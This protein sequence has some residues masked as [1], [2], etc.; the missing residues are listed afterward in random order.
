MSRPAGQDQFELDRLK[1][2]LLAPETDRLAAVEDRVKALDAR[3]GAP[4]RLEKATAEIL[5]EAFRNAEIARHR[6]LANAVAPVIVAAMRSEIRNSKDMMVEALYPITGRLV[7]AAVA[8]AFRD[9]VADLNV[10]LE[11]TLSTQHWRLRLRALMTGRSMS[12]VALAEAQSPQLRR[13]LLLERGS[14]RLIAAWRADGEADETSELVSGL[15]AAITE[16][17]ANVYQAH[18]GEL[19]TLDLGQTRVFLRATPAYLIAADCAGPLRAEDER[20]FD[21]GVLHLVGRLDSGETTPEEGV[22]AVAEGLFEQV[23]PQ[24]K[25]GSRWRLW[26]VALALVALAAWAASGPVLRQMKD[27]AIAA[28][29]AQAVAARP[30]LAA[31]PL[32]AEVDH[33]AGA[34]TLIGVAPTQADVDAVAAALRPAAAPYAVAQTTAIVA[35]SQALAQTDA[36]MADL[37]RRDA[38]AR[39]RL[40]AA[41]A[42]KAD[43]KALR[44]ALAQKADDNAL[45]TA[46]AAANARLAALDVAQKN[47]AAL[48]PDARDIAEKILARAA[49]FFSHD[50]QF[51]DAARAQARLETVAAALAKTDLRVRVVGHA[52]P[53]GSRAR[54]LQLARARADVVI[55]Q[56]A[57]AGVD[58]ARLSPV[59]RADMQPIGV[60]AVDPRDRRVTFEPMFDDEISP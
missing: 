44:A 26:L 41:L 25:A 45:R 59:A 55:D 37:G 8:N 54:N 49:V 11:R 35:A 60:A 1:R 42:Q 17:A 56:L 23:E 9:L 16:F 15:I 36:A 5:V 12:E 29:F 47:L 7:S 24:R 32:R 33:R 31:F 18:D 13:F 6:D 14:G 53:S 38:A 22:A 34:V 43:D 52:D 4:E 10:R 21:D 46:L 40:D 2:L 50:E 51:A 39:E 57:R 58:R 19:R 48:A 30:Q 27:R 28:A 3:V 20:A